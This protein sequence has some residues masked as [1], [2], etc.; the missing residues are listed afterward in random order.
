MSSV[1]TS[2]KG[3]ADDALPDDPQALAELTARTMYA[4]DAA[5][6]ALGA[7]VV[8][9][10]PG[11]AS[12]SMAVRADM[13]NGHKTC[14]G[15]FIFALADSTFAFACNSRNAATVAA[16]CT[17]DYLAPAFEGD[18]LI[19]HAIEYSLSGRTGVYDVQVTNQDGKR[20]AIFRGRS[21]RIKGQVVGG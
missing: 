18:V 6:Q 16:G 20:I 2:T 9:M 3:L 12:M 10:A 8:S 1:P 4:N 5:S 17:I 11:Q 21:Y 13:L 19:A 7:H 15:G 14:H